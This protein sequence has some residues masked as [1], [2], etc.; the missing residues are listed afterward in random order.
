MEIIWLVL[1]AVVG[2]LASLSFLWPRL[3]A[4][5]RRRRRAE[6]ALSRARSEL[7]QEL[8]ETTYLRSLFETL[9]ETFPR[10]VLI[11][12]SDRVILFA[13]P[14]AL[15]LFNLRPDQ[16]VGRVAAAVI[17]DYETTLL[18]MDAMSTFSVRERTFQR[19]TTGQTWRVVV[20]PLPGD[21]T[22]KDA[23][24]P[25]ESTERAQLIVTID[26]LTE[27]RRLETVRQDFVAHVSH[28]LRT[29]LAAAKLLGETLVSALDHDPVAARDFAERINTEI[30]HLSQ[31]VAELLELSR[32]ESGR[33]QLHREPTDVAGLVEVVERRM[34]PLAENAGVTLRAEIPDSLPDV[35][36]DPARLS[37]VLVNLIHNGLKYTP[38]GGSVTIRAE[39]TIGAIA[40]PAPTATN[41]IVTAGK[42]AGVRGGVVIRVVD[43]GIG[44]SADDAQR[45]F[46]RFYKV[47]RART[48][49]KDEGSG[50]SSLDLPGGERDAQM[51]AAAGAGLGL[52]IAKHLVELHGGAIW[53]ESR[54]GHGSVFSFS[55]PAADDTNHDDVVDSDTRVDGVEVAG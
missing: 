20:T 45:V 34:K 16:M 52:A 33:L 43:T 32:I 49:T 30:D 12:D 28:E 23:P 7:R 18:L 6:A 22:V 8:V 1:A 2:G 5:A 24:F 36:A 47:D 9:L 25:S 48:R 38:S 26:D 17:Q 54:L 10:P 14:A 39:A 11:V 50:P 15:R 51:R 41:L 55:L 19:P 37:E 31:M 40:Q 53:V 3:S 13:N 21:D 42:Q 4:S 44:I 29:P 27:L 46:E 35:D